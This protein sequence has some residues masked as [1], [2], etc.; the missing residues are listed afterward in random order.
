MLVVVVQSGLMTPYMHCSFGYKLGT[1]N[2]FQYHFIKLLLHFWICKEN[3]FVLV[4]E[5]PE[6]AE[7][8]RLR[9]L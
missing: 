2:Q 5:G 1:C 7:F 4:I 3:V 6:R 8:R 9:T